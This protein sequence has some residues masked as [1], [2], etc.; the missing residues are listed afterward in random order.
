[1]L[2]AMMFSC[3]TIEDDGGSTEDNTASYEVVHYLQNIENDEFTQ[4]SANTEKGKINT[5][6]KVEA[7]TYEG[8]TA[9]NITQKEIL[10][11][12]STLIE[13]YYE[14]NI[15]TL[16]LDLDGGKGTTTISG[17]YE[18]TVI[19]PANPT[20]TDYTFIQ[21]VP[22]LPTTFPATNT[23]HT[24][25]WTKVTIAEEIN[26]LTEG[27]HTINVTG[28]ISED[29]FS[30]IIFAL[31]RLSSDIYVNLDL[32]KTTGLTSIGDYA[33]EGCSSLTSVIIPDSVTSIGYEAFYDCTGLTSVT[34]PDSVTSID[35]NAFWGCSSLT[36]VT[37]PDSVTSIGGGAFNGCSSLTSVTIPDSVTSIGEGAFEGC[38]SL[39]SVTIPDSVT[40]IGDVAFD[41]CSSLTSVTIPDSVT[42]IGIN[43]F[44]ECSSLTSV[45]IPDSVTFIG[46]AAFSG[47]SSLESIV[48]PDSVTFID[49]NAFYGCSSLTTVNYKGTQ[50]QWGQISIGN[51]NSYY[52]TNA[53]IN[54]NYSGE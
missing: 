45:T 33:F 5:K 3:Q 16:T 13:I 6:T 23:K 4:F 7:K 27:T 26:A 15:I 18:A 10:A 9:K 19:A 20:K 25:K 42:S 48:I 35:S 39:E 44:R 12:G 40:S 50:E 8:F 46:Y 24:A 41:G 2:L 53:T 30:D 49:S 34:I 1:M 11:D 21:W 38:S 37:I 43:A 29:T 22:E 54:Y 47:C 36:S 52:L 28:E 51:S 32:S 17:K 14:R 31:N